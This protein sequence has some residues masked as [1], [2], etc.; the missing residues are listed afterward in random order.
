MK[1]TDSPGCMT[2]EKAR[3]VF[4]VRRWTKSVLRKNIVLWRRRSGDKRRIKMPKYYCDYCDTYL[5]HDSPSVRRTH[6]QGRNHKENVRKYYQDWLEEQAHKLLESTTA[7]FKAGKLP[8]GAAR[9]ALANSIIRPA[10]PLT[11]PFFMPPAPQAPA[12]Q[13][14]PGPNPFFATTHATQLP[15]SGFFPPGVPPPPPH[16]MIPPPGFPPPPPFLQTNSSIPGDPIHTASAH[17][18]MFANFP[19]PPLGIQMPPP[20]PPGMMPPMPVMP[21]SQQPP[22]SSQ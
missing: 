1:S 4:Y 22:N 21:P 13:I 14:L 17:M 8:L 20:P 9:A 2:F 16:F 7:A 12:N 19:P 18:P 11:S 10:L 5:T 15:Q 6:N 3:E